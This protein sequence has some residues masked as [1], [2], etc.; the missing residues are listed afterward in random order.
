MIPIILSGGC[1][2]R[3][4]PYSNKTLPKQYG[5]FFRK[6]LLETT[7]DRFKNYNHYPMVITNVDQ[8]NIIKNS[9]YMGNVSC[10]YEPQSKNTAP[11]IALVCRYFENLNMSNAVIGIFPADHQIKDENSLHKALKIAKNQAQV[12]KII[13]L[14]IEP[15]FPATGYG[16]IETKNRNKESPSFKVSSFKEKP[17]V[18]TAESYIKSNN[19]FWNAGILVFK[20]SAMINEFKTH[21]PQI[22]SVI[23]KLD[24]DL[25]NINEIY[26]EVENISIDHA[27]LEHSTNLECVPADVGWK[28]LGSWDE[29]AK[30]KNLTL[31]D[32]IKSESVL[33]T[34]NSSNNFSFSKTKKLHALIDVDD[35]I[36]IDTPDSLLIAKK[37][38][39]QKVKQLTQSLK[40]KKLPNLHNSEYRPWGNYQSLSEESNFKLKKITVLP[41]ER[42]SYQS[43]ENR[44]EHWIILSGQAEFTLNDEISIINQGEHVFIPKHAKHRIK[45]IG[46]SS[47]VFVEVQVG[48]YFGEDDIT[49]YS[50]DYGRT[51]DANISTA[52]KVAS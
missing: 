6:S 22:W 4:W 8:K 29:M 36:I 52:K 26:S 20:V 5:S 46:Q 18:N 17:N 41:G 3:L 11:A 40:N 7:I 42:L 25:S 10:L 9:S 33:E 12:N 16:Y 39:T 47:L 45:N 19:Y 2:S 13:T 14:G 24:D 15:E 32:S 28:D 31:D 49:R 37:G 38:S 1:G 27:I 43:H 23:E 50:D 51:D 34:I 44:S 30:L 48:T 21:A 35:L